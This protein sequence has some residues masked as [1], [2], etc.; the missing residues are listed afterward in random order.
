MIVSLLVPAV[1]LSTIGVRLLR[2]R[3]LRDCV[4]LLLFAAVDRTGEGGDSSLYRGVVCH[5]G[6]Y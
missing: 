4:G 2:V 5:A 6:K 1:W 3:I